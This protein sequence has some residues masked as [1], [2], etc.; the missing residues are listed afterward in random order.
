MCRIEK[1]T[2][3]AGQ[4]NDHVQPYDIQRNKDGDKKDESLCLKPQTLP[5]GTVL[6]QCLEMITARDVIRAVEGY[7]EY[8][9]IDIRREVKL[10]AA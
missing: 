5:S 3:R 2:G 6:P 9:R 8:K 1:L 7:R 10:V 4:H